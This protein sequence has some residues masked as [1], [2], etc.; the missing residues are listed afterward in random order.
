MVQI[1]TV[2]PVP[3]GWSV[4]NPFSKTPMFFLSGAKAERKAR[5]LGD[6]LVS[7]GESAEVQVR[8]RGGYVVGRLHYGAAFLRGNNQ[9]T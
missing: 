8:G 4:G 1:I 3:G 2:D 6:R 9:Q 7:F 5:E